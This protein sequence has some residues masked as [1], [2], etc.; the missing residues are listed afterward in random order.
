M[1]LIHR[2]RCASTS[3]QLKLYNQLLL[4]LSSAS[5]LLIYD[6]STGWSCL[7]LCPEMDQT[8]ILERGDFTC[9]ISRGIS[10]VK[11]SN[12]EIQSKLKHFGNAYTPQEFIQVV[13][14]VH[15]KSPWNKLTYGS[16]A[17]CL[18]SVWWLVFCVISAFLLYR[19]FCSSEVCRNLKFI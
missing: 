18:L 12:H 3:T 6:I 10:S 7:M 8:I 16:F 2:D 5:S 17:R 13:T 1:G 15:P 4:V 14:T 11:N 19:W 9:C